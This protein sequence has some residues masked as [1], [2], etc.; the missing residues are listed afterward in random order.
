ML[1]RVES[2][3][4][5]NGHARA[6]N[7]IGRDIQEAL[8]AHWQLE[9]AFSDPAMSDFFAIVKMEVTNIS[10]SADQQAVKVRKRKLTHRPGVQL[11]PGVHCLVQLI[12]HTLQFLR[13]TC[14]SEA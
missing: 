3:I 2:Y 5:Q 11:L 1:R 10:A 9:I 4:L 7:K 8:L 13:T 14:I 12:M 6:Q